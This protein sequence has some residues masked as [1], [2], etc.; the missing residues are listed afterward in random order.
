MS[1]LKPCS[2]ASI[3]HE[4]LSFLRTTLVPCVARHRIAGRPCSQSWLCPH[5]PRHAQR[6]PEAAI[7]AASSDPSVIRFLLAT[8]SHWM[9]CGITYTITNAIVPSIPITMSSLSLEL[10]PN[11]LPGVV[12]RE[13]ASLLGKRCSEPI[14]VDE[15]TGMLA[16]SNNGYRYALWKVWDSALPLL[17]FIM[18]NPST[19]DE[20]KPDPTFKKCVGFARRRGAGGLLIGNLFALRATDP[21]VLRQA[22]DPVGVHNDAIVARIMNSKTVE[23]IV[24]AWGNEGRLCGRGAEFLLHWPPTRLRCLVPPG[25]SPFTKDGQPRHPVRIPYNSEFIPFVTLGE[26]LLKRSNDFEIRKGLATFEGETASGVMRAVAE[27]LEK[28]KAE[29]L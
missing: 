27:V 17:G 15:G 4:G 5:W 2:G 13:A 16:S 23:E 3:Q 19:A 1:P 9:V 22:L 20:S 8:G 28:K 26:Q 6:A 25:R 24:I 29:S 7:S 10:M 18:L 14:Q 21:R 12:V 11:P